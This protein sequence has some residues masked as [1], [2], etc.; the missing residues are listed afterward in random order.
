MAEWVGRMPDCQERN[1]IEGMEEMPDISMDSLQ[2]ESMIADTHHSLTQDYTGLVSGHQRPLAVEEAHQ[3]MLDAWADYNTACDMRKEDDY[4][5]LKGI[6]TLYWT[7]QDADKNYSAVYNLWQTSL[8]ECSCRQFA[9][10][11]ETL[12]RAC[13]ARNLLKTMEDGEMPY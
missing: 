5:A 13:A 1:R 6:Q 12:C 10:D 8:Q 7:A 11:R 3:L 2:G 9:P 4:E